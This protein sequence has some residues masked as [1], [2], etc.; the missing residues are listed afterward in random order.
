MISVPV[1]YVA[2]TISGYLL[3]FRQFKI[4]RNTLKNVGILEENKY[5]P[6]EVR[7]KTVPR[8]KIYESV[9]S[10]GL[11]QKYALTRYD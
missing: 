2:N 7:M 4:F 10:K 11:R 8:R 1:R 9:G 6:T 3:E 5:F